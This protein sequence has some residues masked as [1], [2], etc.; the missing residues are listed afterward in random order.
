M[1]DTAVDGPDGFEPSE[2]LYNSDLAPV[3]ERNWGTYSLFAM[4]MSDA[5]PVG[6]AG[7]GISSIRTS[8]GTRS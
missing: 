5:T 7:S 4:W 8:T 1:S 2:R 3:R 6:R